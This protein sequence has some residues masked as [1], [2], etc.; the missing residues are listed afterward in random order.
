VVAEWVQRIRA[1]VQ[2]YLDF[3]GENAATV[4]NNLD[5]TGDLSTLDFLRDVGKHFPVN[6]MLAREVV[7]SRPRGGRRARAGD[8]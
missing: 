2:K 1:Q 6:R 7:R 3:E 4:V 8:G 5:W